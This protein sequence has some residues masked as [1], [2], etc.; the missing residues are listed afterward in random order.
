MKT[1]L[2]I[3]DR[4]ISLH[5]LPAM[6]VGI[7]DEDSHKLYSLIWLRTM[8]CQMEPSISEQ[9]KMHVPLCY[10]FSYSVFYFFQLLI[11]FII[12][13]CGLFNKTQCLLFFL[14]KKILP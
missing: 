10:L 13:T 4:F 6:L 12:V 2:P 9:V 1:F 8:A 14:I 11:N 5:S 3:I 7:L